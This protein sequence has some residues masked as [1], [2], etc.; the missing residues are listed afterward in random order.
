LVATAGS[1]AAGRNI[2]NSQI[3]I[4]LAEEDVE[5]RHREQLT[6]QDPEGG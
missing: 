5:R 2:E 4:G 6:K 3:T 1:V